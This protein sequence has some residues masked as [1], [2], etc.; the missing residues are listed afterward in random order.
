MTSTPE[1]FM[2]NAIDE[3]LV[4]CLLV[5]VLDPFGQTIC[6]MSCPDPAPGLTTLMHAF[7]TK[8]IRLPFVVPMM[9]NSEPYS[10][11][12]TSPDGREPT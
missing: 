2:N 8:E 1:D 9:D 11:R 6:A 12:I 3:G 10:V 7:G 4:F 5:E